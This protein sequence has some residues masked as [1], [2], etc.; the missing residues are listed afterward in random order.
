M[1]LLLTA[2]LVGPSAAQ[3]AALKVPYR[4]GE[5]LNFSV[6]WT[7]GNIGTAYM[8][9]AAID[10]FCGEPCYRI[11]AGAQSNK[12]IDLFY[13]VRDIFLSLIDM[14]RLFSRKFVKRQKEGNTQRNRELIFDQERHRRLDL[15]A[16][17]TVD[18]VSE[19]QDELSIFY[20]FRTLNLVEGQ[21]QLLENFEDR[22]G[23][24]LKVMVLRTEWVEVPAGRFHCYVVEPYIE[25]GGL[26]QHKGN[27]LI[28]ITSDEH[29][30]PVKVTSDLDF[31][32]IYVLLE[33]YRLGT[34]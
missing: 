27:L 13:P 16:G 10:S 20:Y 3:E 9:V 24:P 8:H 14:K 31:G 7:V 12:T 15:V 30:I 6:N 23:N 25:S 2:G 5:Q 34:S 17:D 19:A 21:G 22:H 33:D 26:F 29:R 4:V 11:E 28:W 18:V 1:A 32:R